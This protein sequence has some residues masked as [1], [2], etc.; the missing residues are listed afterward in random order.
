V[1]LDDKLDPVI[2]DP[3]QFDQILTNLVVNARDAMPNGGKL[4]I[5]NS[6]VVLGDDYVRANPRVRSGRYVELTIVDT[7]VG[8]AP[9]TVARVFEPF[10]TTKSDQGGSGLGLASVY[11]MVD[12][13][14][15]HIEVSSEV[16]KGSTF[17]VY[18]PS[19]GS[20]GIPNQRLTGG[21]TVLLVEPEALTR[22]DIEQKLLGLGYGV[23]SC[24][25]SRQA[26]DI[27]GRGRDVSLVVANVL[28]GG[29]NSLELSREL[30][31]RSVPPVTLHYASDTGGVLADRG[32]LGQHVEVLQLPVTA[33]VLGERI[34][35]LLEARPVS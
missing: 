3:A 1:E 14:G 15:G 26:L 27:I 23:I 31:K 35:A 19:Q 5:R 32:V 12:K 24:R 34:R 4:T 13:A 16:G 7:G 18:M 11:A 28:M 8:M 17:R 2:A 22:S 29:M 30:A 10:F 20:S 33:E 21:E 25:S 9:D 6:N